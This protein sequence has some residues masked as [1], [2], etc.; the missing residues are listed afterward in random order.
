MQILLS[1][2]KIPRDSGYFQCKTAINYIPLKFYIFVFCNV[3][4]YDAINNMKIIP[5]EIR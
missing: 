4:V 3:S 2:E 1:K 5:L